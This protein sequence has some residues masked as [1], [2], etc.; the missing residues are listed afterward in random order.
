MQNGQATTNGAPFRQA[1]VPIL[2]TTGVFFFNFLSRTLLAPFLPSIEEEF[3]ISHALAG[4]LYFFTVIGLAITLALSGF[5]S[6]AIG[7]RRTIQL[8]AFGVGFALLSIAFAPN[9]VSLAFCLF[10][11]GASSGMYIPSGLAAITH[12]SKKADWGK[13]LSIH[14]IAPNLCFIFSPALVAM[15]AGYWGRSEVFVFIAVGALLMGVVFSFFGPRF[16]AVGESPRPS[17]VKL[18]VTRK[19]FWLYAGLFALGVGSSMTPYTMLPLFLVDEHGMDITSAGNLLSLSRF[20]G[21]FL[22]ILTGF[23]IDRFG[24]RT[25]MTSTLFITGLFTIFLGIGEGFI[26]KAAVVL[27]PLATVCFF[28]AAFTSI[29]EAFA[30]DIRNVAISLIIPTALAFSM[31]IIPVLLGGLG[32]AGFFGVGF[33]LLGFIVLTGAI[34]PML[35]QRKKSKDK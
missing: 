28:P 13:A 27:Q 32:D 29:T 1:L 16:Q 15:T 26:L 17:I 21:P 7:H 9:F 34:F 14:E 20:P 35:V 6:K 3:G 2:I 23:F 8:S 22:A 25:M 18:L 33:T 11:L 24:A 12:V 4:S 10:L 19:V 31:G 5:V 30:P